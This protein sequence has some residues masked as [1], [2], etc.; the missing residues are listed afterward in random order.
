MARP[1]KKGLSYFPHDC[2]A[3]ND[4][5]IEALRM[6]Y[7][8]DGYAFFFILLERIYRTE[9]FELDISDSETIQILSK[10][11]GINEDAFN[12]ILHT[13]L[14]RGCFDA[15]VYEERK[16]LTSNGIKK[17][18]EVVVDKR[19]K[20]RAKYEEKKKDISDAE[21]RKETQSETAQSK[22]NK[23]KEK[24]NILPFKDGSPEMSLTLE[25]ILLMQKNNPDVKIPK[26]LDRWAVEIDRM[27]RL[28]RRNVDDIRKVIH[29]SQ[30]DPFW[31]SNILSTKKLREKFDT[32]YLKCRNTN[33]Q[34][35]NA[36][37]LD[38]FKQVLNQIRSE[39]E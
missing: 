37:E 28:D 15:Q 17:R 22:L 9:D 19:E 39:G 1:L 8:N 6:L 12:Q 34:I 33:P 3:V 25:L 5:K 36:D 7:G 21:T 27:I 23:N 32:L 18:A 4:E 2:D 26:D 11:I 29:F 35:I 30:T 13:A 20:M 10:K 14:K 16:V 38:S 24:K 31:Q